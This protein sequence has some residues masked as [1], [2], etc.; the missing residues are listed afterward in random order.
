MIRDLSCHVFRVFLY[1]YIFAIFLTLVYFSSIVWLQ[2]VM[3]IW[4]LD[5]LRILWRSVS[6]VLVRSSVRSPDLAVGDLPRAR[7]QQSKSLR[8]EV[9]SEHL[10]S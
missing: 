4:S 9:L 2:D 7:R 1:I 8:E 3:R 10:G 6:R 5:V